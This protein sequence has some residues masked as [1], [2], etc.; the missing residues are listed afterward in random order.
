[1]VLGDSTSLSRNA[2]PATTSHWRTARAKRSRLASPA[3]IQTTPN[4][5]PRRTSW[6]GGSEPSGEPGAGGTPTIG[7][8]WQQSASRGG[9]NFSAGGRWHLASVARVTARDGG[10]LKPRRPARSAAYGRAVWR[11]AVSF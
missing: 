11:A 9:E 8:H 4:L 1:M 5:R 6:S 3:A 7:R 2:L 10:M